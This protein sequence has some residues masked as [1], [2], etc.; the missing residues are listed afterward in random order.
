MGGPEDRSWF[1]ENVD[2]WLTTT[3][4]LMN[5]K[6]KNPTVRNAIADLTQMMVGDGALVSRATKAGRTVG[7]S[8][9]IKATANHF[10]TIGGFNKRLNQAFQAYRKDLSRVGE[11]IVGYNPGAIGIKAGDLVDSAI[12]KV[13]GRKGV[14]RR[15]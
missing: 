6:I 8:A 13:G 12:R 15:S 11:P 2:R 4:S 1:A 14:T 9:L 7:Q 5:N 3:G 10:K